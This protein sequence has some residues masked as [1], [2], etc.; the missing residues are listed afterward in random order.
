MR[1]LLVSMCA[2]C[3]ASFAWAMLRHFDP[4]GKPKPGMAFTAAVVPLIATLPLL[5]LLARPFLFPL[6]ALSFYVAGGALFWLAV[7]ATRQRG[8]A[9]CF[10]RRVPSGVVSVGAYRFIRHPFYTAYMLAWTAAFIATGWWPLGFSMLFLTI[11]YICAARKEEHDFLRSPLREE[12]LLYA[13]T[14]GRFLP[15]MR[16]VNIALFQFRRLTF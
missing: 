12:Y 11:L 4:A 5:S 16:S 2:A 7:A 1:I 10:Q 9:A 14:T 6:A 15:R 8:L 13:R 3:F